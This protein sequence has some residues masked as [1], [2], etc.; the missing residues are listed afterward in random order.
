V[1]DG[2]LRREIIEG[3]IS[4]AENI[5][6]VSGSAIDAAQKVDARTCCFWDMLE[7]FVLK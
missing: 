3:Q 2:L 5:V 1:E 4:T 7:R 6:Y